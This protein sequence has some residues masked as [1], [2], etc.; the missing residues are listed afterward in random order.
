MSA[1]GWTLG[2]WLAE[3]YETYKKPYLSAYSLRNIEQMIR[4]HI[5]ETLKRL[6][7]SELTAYAVERELAPLGKSRT[8][9]YAR[10][11]LFS[12]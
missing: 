9:V 3:W 8:R 10:Q 4:L 11:V 1:G 12:A 6:P 7:L 5:P 2:E